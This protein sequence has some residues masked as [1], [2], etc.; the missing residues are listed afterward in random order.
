MISRSGH[1]RQ[2][3]LRGLAALALLPLLLVAA[4]GQGTEKI[5]SPGLYSGYSAAV[6]G[7]WVRVSQYIK[8][9]DGTMLAADI[10]RP[11][12]NGQP[13]AEPLPVIWAYDR[14]HR[15]DI[16]DGR[17]ITELD[18]E[19]WLQTV[20]KHGYVVGVVDIRGT[21]ASLGTWDAPFTREEALD[22]YDITEWFAAQPWCNQRV[23]MFGRSYLGI[24]QYATAATAPPHLKAIFPEMAMFD[25][26]SF[27]YPG[28]VFRRDFAVK[29]GRMV[30]YLDA[31]K[32][33]APVDGDDGK[34]L[35]RAVAGHK[36]NRDLY[37]VFASMPYADSIDPKTKTRLY[38]SNSPSRYQDGIRKSGVAVYHLS[39]WYDMW[40]RDAFLWFKSLTNRQ[41]IIIG[42]W[43]HGQSHGFDLAAE[44]LRWYDYWLKGIDNKIMSEPPIT[45]YTVGAPAGQQ[46]RSAWQWPLPEEQ[47]TSYHFRGGS[48]GSVHSINDGLLSAEPASDG[49]GQ[50]DY[51]VNF[52][53]TS[54]TSTRWTNGYGGAYG[55]Q[56]M[57]PNDEKG[58]TYTTTPL[59][60]DVEVT[61]HPVVH[62]WV[63]S[64]AGDGDFI[65][66]LEE[67]YPNGNAQYVTEGVLRAS[68][69]AVAAPTAGQLPLPFHRNFAKDTGELHAEP[70]ELAFDLLPISKIFGAGNRIRVTIVGADRDNLQTNETGPPPVFGVL[71]SAAHDSHIVLPIIPPSS[72][73][74]AEASVLPEV[75]APAVT[76]ARH[77]PVILTS[78]AVVLL[79]SLVG[80]K[81]VGRHKRGEITRRGGSRR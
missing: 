75:S 14:Y 1:R 81:F 79:L 20:L 17:L 73:R 42:P 62:L 27:I 34:L 65:A 63:T 25:L 7:E 4:R 54:G 33:A 59:P 19:P 30:N 57:T 12:Q 50:D 48:T 74:P 76:S 9:R 69:R 68:H 66:Y 39:G 8:A 67:V 58:L 21:G 11:A 2:A 61:G 35:A 45:Y 23:G 47:Q 40:S 22:G 37:D 29:W 55:Y 41:K 52:S 72:P 31:L 3:S 77:L 71:L 70:A 78:I 43:S 18:R 38:L 32:P 49:D 64:Q 53:T 15:A 13:V 51:T 46:W 10:F 44:H 16:Q 56:N 60:A 6:Y 24:T 26:Y 36:L 80:F 28:G 5:S